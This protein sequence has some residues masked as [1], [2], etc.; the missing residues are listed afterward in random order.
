MMQ[1]L[2]RRLAIINAHSSL[3]DADEPVSQ[4]SVIHVG[5]LKTALSS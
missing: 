5:E 4:F 1:W 3:S 2:P